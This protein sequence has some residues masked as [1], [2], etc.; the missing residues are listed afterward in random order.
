MSNSGDSSLRHFLGLDGLTRT[1]LVSL[2][3]LAETFV[4]PPGFAAARGNSLA[5]ITVANVF[6]EPSTRTRASFQ[7]AAQRLGA[8]LLNLDVAHSSRSKGEADADTLQTLAAMGVSLF[9]V[10]T[11]I[12][13]QPARLAAALEPHC[14]LINAGEA[15][16]AHPTQGLLDVFTIRAHRPDT[17]QLRVAIVGDIAH[18]RVARSAIRGLQLLGI[19]EICLV[20]PAAF[21]PDPDE[22]ADCILTT[23]LEEGL[24]DADFVMTLRIQRERMAQTEIPDSEDYFAHY[25]LSED[26]LAVAKPGALVMHPGPINRGVEIDD[27]LADGPRSVIREQVRNGVAVRMALLQTLAEQT[28]IGAG[29]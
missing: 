8:T 29:K 21:L 14:A 20:G 23:R 7:L 24:A 9:V 19:G 1:Q 10:R 12:A 11:G 15:E 25:G 5:D 22:F 27:A 17:D 28:A 6:F 4:R 18:S 13:G 2:L 26:R 3:D 16:L